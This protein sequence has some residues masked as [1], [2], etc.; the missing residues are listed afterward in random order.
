MACSWAGRQPTAVA[1]FPWTE[2]CRRGQVALPARR[3]PLHPG[4]VDQTQFRTNNVLFGQR[5]PACHRRVEDASEDLAR[6]FIGRSRV[7]HNVMSLAA[8]MALRVAGSVM[9]SPTGLISLVISNFTLSA[10]RTVP[11]RAEEPTGA[12]TLRE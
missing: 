3:G 9:S 2:C 8:I 11:Q 7:H 4:G 5:L 12:G 1:G 10:V 6:L